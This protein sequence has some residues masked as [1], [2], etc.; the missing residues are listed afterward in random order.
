MLFTSDEIEKKIR[1]C[2]RDLGL[3]NEIEKVPTDALLTDHGLDSIL[4]MEFMLKVEEKF[5]VMFDENLDLD[6]L[7]VIGKLVDYL[8]ENNNESNL[9]LK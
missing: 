9:S 7:A 2:L 8:R 3:P 4:L 5:D 6:T 1:M